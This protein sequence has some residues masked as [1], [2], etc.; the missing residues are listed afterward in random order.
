MG[1]VTFV[2]KNKEITV[3]KTT[4]KGKTVYKFPTL[5]KLS[6]AGKIQLWET[7]VIDD[8]LYSQSGFIDGAMKPTSKTIEGV[9]KSTAQEQ[10]IFEGQSAWKKKKD[11]LYTEE[12]PSEDANE[13]QD[14]KN[15]FEDADNKINGQ[16][17]RPML[18]EAWKKYS[19]KA[20]F[21]GGVSPK[22][23]GVR[24][25]IF[26]DRNGDIVL[27]SRQGLH[28]SHLNGIRE[29]ARQI[30]SKYDVVLD[31]ELYSHDIP[32]N[33][34][35]G[36]ARTKDKPSKHDDK[37]EYYIFDLIVRGDP[38]MSYR[39][40]MNLL[41][42]ICS[43]PKNS[44]NRL[45]FLFYETV[46]DPKDIPAIHARYTSEGYEGLMFRNLD[47]KYEVKRRTTN[48]L[49]YKEFEDKEFEIVNVLQGS[50][51]EEGAAV[52][53]CVQPPQFSGDVPRYFTVRPRGTMET[54]RK[55]FKNARKLIGKMLTVRYQPLKEDVLPRFP[56]GI[57]IRDYE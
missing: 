47:S 50:G 56:V 52:F 14:G 28:Y 18:A 38:D 45:R 40:R 44:Y 16:I 5:Y 26:F 57:D 41:R 11:S 15:D 7:W 33:E 23:D 8:V 31:G 9:G 24:V 36:V 19:H 49:K 25:M 32:F 29:E 3:D 53:E 30:I 27:M 39:D 42:K 13:P 37:I 51:N 35:S 46:N 1:K 6:K 22:L 4:S 17:I 20:K 12:M 43:D 34:I 54:R 21:P 2:I 10:A 48:L 55:W